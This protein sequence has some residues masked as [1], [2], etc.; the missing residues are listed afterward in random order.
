MMVHGGHWCGLSPMFGAVGY[1]VIFLLGGVSKELV[2]ITLGGGQLT[3]LCFFLLFQ[4]YKIVLFSTLIIWPCLF[5]S[6]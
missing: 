5:S 3:T 2:D 1:G 6:K 4:V